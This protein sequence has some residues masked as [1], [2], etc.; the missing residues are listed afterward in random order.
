MYISEFKFLSRLTAGVT[1]TLAVVLSSTS[2]S[3]TVTLNAPAAERTIT[4]TITDHSQSRTAIDGT[5]YADGRTGLI[6]TAGDRIGVY[7]AATKNAPFENKTGATGGR[8]PFAGTLAGDPLCAYYPYSEVNDGCEAD[9]LRGSLPLTQTW[10]EATRTVDGD[11]KIGTLR[12]GADDEFDFTHLFALLRFNVNASGTAIEGQTLRSVTI[13]LPEGRTLGGDFTFSAV[14]GNPSFTGATEGANR[15]TIEWVNSPVLTSGTTASAYASC[16]PDMRADDE[17][18]ITVTT[19]TH[20][21]RFTRHVAYDFAADCVYTFDLNLKLYDDWTYEEIPAEP[22]EETANC[23]MINT[24]GEHDFKATV[25]GNGQKGIIPGAGFH[26][27]DARISPVS[28]KL[29]WQD[30]PNFITDVELRSDGRIYYTNTLTEGNALIAALDASGAVL[31]S[32]HIWGVGD[33]MPEDY[34]ITTKQGST[35]E[36]MDRNLGAFP[37]TDAQR[38][39]TVR[40]AENEARVLHCMLYQWGRKDP[41]PNSDKYYVDGEEINIASSFP[42][43]Q[44]AT[45]AEATIAASVLRPDQMMNR[46]ADSS[47]YHWLGTD[48]QLLWG[49]DRD[50]ELKDGGWTHGKTIYDPSPVGY[51]VANRFTFTNFS[52]YADK[53]NVSLSG[54][55]SFRTD[56]DGNM[57]KTGLEEQI[58]CVVEFFYQNTTLRWHPK[59]IHNERIGFAYGSS[60]NADKIFGYGTYMKRHDGDEEGNYYAAGGYRFPNPKGA[61]TYFAKSGH[62]WMSRGNVSNTAGRASLYMSNFVYLTGVGNYKEPDKGL[63]SGSGTKGSYNVNESSDPWCAQAVRCVRE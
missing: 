60:A 2:C 56:E 35:F 39:E 7:S 40:T 27:E 33:T 28:A 34:T 41:F 43:W 30:T 53:T 63:G 11:Y 17:I 8:I 19:D 50:G 61:R 32:W 44:P 49:D 52:P 9:N 20:T 15:L 22:E 59:G 26:T 36:I 29:L 31:W 21:A 18:T 24:V 1:A 51:R 13:E 46:P 4:A 16:A 57:T 37:T 54:T 45:S 6:W 55:L 48:N 62:W 14:S 58:N 42:V 12:E 23:Y 47:D 25:I 5:E 38:L 10:D 3:E